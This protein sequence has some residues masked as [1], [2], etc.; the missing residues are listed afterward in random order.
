MRLRC[1][2]HPRDRDA[3]AA[4]RASATSRASTPPRRAGRSRGSAAAKS[5]PAS[6]FQR[7]ASSSPSES[8]FSKPG[9]VSFARPNAAPVVSACSARPARLAG[10]CARASGA[11]VGAQLF[12]TV[13][14]CPDA[15]ARRPPP[16][17]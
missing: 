15:K 10:S 3:G 6:L 7:A 17:C 8:S 5:A 12:P 1:V 16:P 9:A 13:F 2:R 11:R 14:A 4:L